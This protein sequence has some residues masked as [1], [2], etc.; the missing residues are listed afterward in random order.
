M[1]KMVFISIN[2]LDGEIPCP[3]VYLMVPFERDFCGQVLGRV[4]MR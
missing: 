3:F 2:N 1:R 4:S